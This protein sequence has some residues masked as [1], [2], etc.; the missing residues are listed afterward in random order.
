MLR[1]R[2]TFDLSNVYHMYIF[3]LN[4]NSQNNHKIPT[5]TQSDIKNTKKISE[6]LLKRIKIRFILLFQGI[7]Y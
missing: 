3:S 7:S 4:L 2:F 1:S 5:K 6:E